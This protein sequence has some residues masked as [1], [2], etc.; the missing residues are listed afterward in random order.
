MREW[1]RANGGPVGLITVGILAAFPSHYIG[2]VLIL[3]GLFWY[4]FT[5]QRLKSW[6]PFGWTGFGAKASQ[7]LS[8]TYISDEEI[9]IADLFPPGEA[10]VE[11]KTFERCEF[12]GPAVVAF[13]GSCHL[14]S[15]VFDV[16]GLTPDA[17]LWELEADRW[18]LGGVAFRDCTLRD[19]RFQSCGIAGTK[20]DLEPFRSELLQRQQAHPAKGAA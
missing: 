3:V 20:A 15:P 9:R 11:G 4:V 8:R 19:C 6:L 5:H 10:V 17:L 12:L 16:S 1:A 7:N 13:T 14:V 2:I 18:V